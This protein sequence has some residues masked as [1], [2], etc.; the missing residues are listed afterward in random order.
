MSLKDTTMPFA[1][2][3]IPWSLQ[4]CSGEGRL[5]QQ[6]IVDAW[7]SIEQSELNWVRHNQKTIRAD[8]YDALRDALRGVQGVDLGQMGK[9]IVLPA[10]HPGS[11]RHMYQLFQ[12][13]MAI[14]RHCGKPDIFLTMT[15]N[16][17]WAEIQDNLLPYEPDDDDPDQREKHQTASDRPDIV[18][19]VFAQKIKAMLK[20]IK[21]GVFGDV[22]GYVFTVEFQKRG[23]PHIHL[24]IFLGDLTRSAMPLMLTPSSPLRS[25]TLWLIPCCMRPSQSA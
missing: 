25:L 9:R 2:T 23:L 12:D 17:N 5:F 11:A 1:F 24:L 6:Y 8:L 13:S 14:A 21:D 15:A 19:R 16:P 4:I 18:A 20:D 10:S 3:H 7:A 22:H